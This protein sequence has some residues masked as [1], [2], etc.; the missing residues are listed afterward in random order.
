MLRMSI[1]WLFAM[2]FSTTQLSVNMH[3]NVYAVNNIDIS[4]EMKMA[5]RTTSVYLTKYSLV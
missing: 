1:I 4:T 5:K 2:L 3:L